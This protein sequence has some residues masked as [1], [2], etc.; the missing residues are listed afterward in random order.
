MSTCKAAMMSFRAIGILL[1][2]SVHWVVAVPQSEAKGIEVKSTT[3]RV[4]QGMCGSGIQSG[5]GHTGCAICTAK[6]CADYDCSSA[7]C[8]ITVFIKGTPGTIHT[9]V[10][11]TK[12]TTDEGTGSGPLRHPVNIETGTKPVASSGSNNPPGKAGGISSGGG[13]RR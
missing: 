4:V 12:T 6:N 11:G 2:C 8:K 1:L 9:G 10:T 3:Q 5:N 7:G 13:Y